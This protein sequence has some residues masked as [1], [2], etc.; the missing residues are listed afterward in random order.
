MILEA[1]S[2]R[3]IAKPFSSRQILSA[4]KSLLGGPI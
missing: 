3:W 1:G 4:I 2:I